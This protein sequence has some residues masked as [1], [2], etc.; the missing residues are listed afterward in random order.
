MKSLKAAPGE[1]P[2]IP[3][4]GVI[5]VWLNL[6]EYSH[7]E[8]GWPIWAG[9]ATAALVYRMFILPFT[10]ASI[11]HSTKL[12][13]IKDIH[14]TRY[15]LWK[16]TASLNYA[17]RAAEKVK[18]RRVLKENK[19]SR[20]LIF[21]PIIFS[22]PGFITFSWSLR[23]ACAVV[24]EMTTSG[25][26]WFKDMTMYDPELKLVA[27][28]ALINTL[29]YLWMS[30]GALPPNV[31]A[32]ILTKRLF[33]TFFL[34]DSNSRNAQESYSLLQFVAGWTH[35]LLAL[36]R[37]L[38]SWVALVCDPRNGDEQNCEGHLQENEVRSS[39]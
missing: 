13:N 36:P 33:L 31:S 24:P 2:D 22:I 25:F 18:Y 37:V 3:I 30:R 16:A 6:F 10:V 1:M 19:V 38:G 34:Q 11:H 14:V 17:Q 35:C 23:V 5:S 26:L 12:Q 39:L 4:N 8:L 15:N 9:T 21:S 7:W 29:S 20:F 32:S 28:V 27:L